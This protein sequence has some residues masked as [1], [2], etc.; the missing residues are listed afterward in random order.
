MYE[1][2]LVVSLIFLGEAAVIYGQVSGAQIAS[3]S[4]NYSMSSFALPATMVILGSVLLMAGYML[5]ILGL[6]NIWVVSVTSIGSVL[7][8]EPILNYL[9]FTQLPT[10]GAAIGFVLAVFGVLSSLLIK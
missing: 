5:G 6:K 9:I 1:K 10:L 2:L 7:V 4:P 3:I 8:N